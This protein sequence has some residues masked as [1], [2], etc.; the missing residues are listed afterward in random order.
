[1]RSIPAEGDL[2]G[3]GMQLSSTRELLSL[4]DDSGAAGAIEQAK[5]QLPS[6][7]RTVDLLRFALLD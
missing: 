7:R 3:V 4:H 6:E 5:G 2:S 1:M